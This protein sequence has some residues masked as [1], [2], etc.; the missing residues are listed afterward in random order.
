MS[1]LIEKAREEITKTDEEIVQLLRRRMNLVLE[2]GRLKNEHGLPIRDD[3]RERKVLDHIRD[4][5]DEPLQ[6]DELVSLFRRI[7][8]MCRNAQMRTRTSS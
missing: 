6:K 3:I 2:I 5:A 7:I 4:I 1:R 8:E